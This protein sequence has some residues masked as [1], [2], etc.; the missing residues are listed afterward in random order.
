MVSANE[1]EQWELVPKVGNRL[2]FSY[3]LITLLSSET[4][5][6]FRGRGTLSF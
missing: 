6:Q 4:S 3:L 1:T 2:F 5:F